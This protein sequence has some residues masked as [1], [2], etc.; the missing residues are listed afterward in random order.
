MR[1]LPDPHL[2]A[3]TR[4]QDLHPKPVDSKSWSDATAAEIL[5]A[6]LPIILATSYA[7]CQRQR[8]QRPHNPYAHEGLATAITRAFQNA[9]HA[10]ASPTRAPGLQ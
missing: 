5:A 10:P 4:Q 3:F 2:L 6:H 7:G 8:H 1:R 9:K